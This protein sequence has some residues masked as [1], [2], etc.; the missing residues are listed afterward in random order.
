MRNE[1]KKK[2][3]RGEGGKKERYSNQLA[4]DDYLSRGTVRRFFMRCSVYALI[5]LDE[6][7][8][9]VQTAL[10]R[11]QSLLYPPSPFSTLPFVLCPFPIPLTHANIRAS[12]YDTQARN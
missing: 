6:R 8:K 3:R 5:Q 7:K 12:R 10:Q 2:G 11:R 4:S 1:R 9:I